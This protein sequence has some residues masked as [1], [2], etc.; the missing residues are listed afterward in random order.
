MLRCFARPTHRDSGYAVVVYWL[1]SG[2]ARPCR[3]LCWASK[4]AVFRPDFFIAI[5]LL[6]GWRNK[7]LGKPDYWKWCCGIFLY[8]RFAKR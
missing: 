6:T 8:N 2:N 7:A 4:G 3:L 5:G 1:Y